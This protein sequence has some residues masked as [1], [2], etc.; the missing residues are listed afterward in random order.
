MIL[1]ASTIGY[2]SANTALFILSSTVFIK[3]LPLQKSWDF[4]KSDKRQYENEK[5]L[6]LLSTVI[7]FIL[8]FKIALTLYLFYMIDSLTPFIKAAMCG[9]GVLNA[10][11]AGWELIGLKI[12]MLFAFLLWISL[13][14]ADKQ[15]LNY[16]YAKMKIGFYFFIFVLLLLEIVTDYAVIFSLDTQKVV[17]CCSVTFSNTNV[18]GSIVLPGWKVIASIFAA[19]AFLHILFLNLSFLKYQ[20][21]TMLSFIFSVFFIVIGIFSI[22]YFISPYIYENPSH[23]CPFCILQKEYYYVGYLLYI[24]VF[25][26]SYYG[27]ESAFKKVL[28]KQELYEQRVKALLFSL[29]FVLLCI[30]FIFSYIYTNGVNLYG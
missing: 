19:S 21:F 6:H 22:I 23:T 4:N 24:T 26:G 12:F 13:D 15:M 29:L 8:Y 25:L 17:S 30:W 10:T 16:P 28:L 2:L 14:K 5:V 9:V 1:T 20:I 27:V 3:A 7:H 11:N 18:V